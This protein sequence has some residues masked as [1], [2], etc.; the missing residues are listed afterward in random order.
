MPCGSCGK[1]S[2]LMRTFNAGA[3]VMTAQSSP[4]PPALR[5]EEDR[6]A[7]TYAGQTANHYIPSPARKVRH[8]GYGGKGM[9][10]V[11]HREDVA[12]RPDVFIPQ[13]IEE[14]KK[15]WPNYPEGVPQNVTD[16]LGLPV[17]AKPEAKTLPLTWPD[18]ST[19]TIAE[20]KNLGLGAA[21]WDEVLRQEEAGSKRRTLVEYAKLQLEN[22]E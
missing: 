16:L 20:I 4:V 6:V 10:L 1:K 17:V 8:Y 5:V 14:A 2:S 22:A 7:V 21:G 12:K 9:S 15:V 18:F 13:S 19:L 11:A 3:P